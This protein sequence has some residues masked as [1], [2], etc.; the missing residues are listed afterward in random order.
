MW[1]LFV[2]QRTWMWKEMKGADHVAKKVCSTG[3]KNQRCFLFSN[4]QGKPDGKCECGEGENVRHVISVQERKLF[5]DLGECGETV[6]NMCRLLKP[7]RKDWNGKENVGMSGFYWA[8]FPSG[9]TLAN[10]R[11]QQYA[12][13]ASSASNPKKKKT[14]KKRKSVVIS[15]L[16]Q[17]WRPFPLTCLT[18]LV[19]L[20]QKL[21]KTPYIY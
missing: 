4:K 7:G 2:V 16:V 1:V 14:K 3:G 19:D 9:V 8:S 17:V 15:W 13:E 6:F 12:T 11:G 21:K 20:S 10:S 5:K 18:R